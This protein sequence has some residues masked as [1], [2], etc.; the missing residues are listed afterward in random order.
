[1]TRTKTTGGTIMSTGSAWAWSAVV[2]AYPVGASARS[3]P[4]HSGPQP[5]H[6]SMAR[7]HSTGGC[8]AAA[9][10]ET[11]ATPTCPIARP[12]KRLFW[13]R[14]SPSERLIPADIYTHPEREDVLSSTP[15][16]PHLCAITH[17]H[18]MHL[19]MHFHYAPSA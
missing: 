14:R 2:A 11:L 17:I 4:T 8:S 16:H 12:P 7:V 5:F 15:S 9:D 1:M 13:G 19:S 6:S 18:G 10:A 3:C